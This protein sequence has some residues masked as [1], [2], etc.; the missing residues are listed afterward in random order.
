MEAQGAGDR[1]GRGDCARSP[2][3]LKDRI[4]SAKW[5]KRSSAFDGACELRLLLRLTYIIEM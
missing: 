4:R 3:V 2:R 5:Q 1:G